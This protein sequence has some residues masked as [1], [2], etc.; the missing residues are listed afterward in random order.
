MRDGEV[1]FIHPNCRIAKELSFAAQ[2]FNSIEISG[3]DSSLQRPEYFEEWASAT[4]DAFVFA[5]KAP[6]LSLT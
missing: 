4:P 5:V 6:D 3:T 2:V 1:S